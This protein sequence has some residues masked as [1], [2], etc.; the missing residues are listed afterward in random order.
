MGIHPTN[1]NVVDDNEIDTLLDS[2]PSESTMEVIGKIIINLYFYS[3][4]F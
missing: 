1:L 4:N 2:T 3:N